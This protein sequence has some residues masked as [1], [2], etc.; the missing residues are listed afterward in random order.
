MAGNPNW[1][2]GGESPNPNGRK[3]TRYSV[4]TPK[5]LLENFIKKNITPARLQRMFDELDSKDQLKFLTEVLPFIIPKQTSATMDINFDKLTDSDLDLLYQR[6]TQNLTIDL[7]PANI[8]SL[9]EVHSFVLPHNNRESNEQ[10]A[11]D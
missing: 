3:K 4:R 8:N 5:G 11:K 10:A 2:K 9:S 1:K 7:V 6:V